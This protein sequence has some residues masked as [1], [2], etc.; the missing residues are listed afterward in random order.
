MMYNIS[1]DPSLHQS[2]HYWIN[3]LYVLG[4]GLRRASAAIQDQAALSKPVVLFLSC[5]TGT[6]ISS[7]DVVH[8][9]NEISCTTATPQTGSKMSDMFVLIDM[10]V[11]SRYKLG[12][13]TKI[14]MEKLKI[15][16]QLTERKRLQML[17]TVVRTSLETR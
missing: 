12:N 9:S 3:P 7:A 2:N 14:I 13:Q 16:E 6:E 10:T 11:S 15:Q 5:S 17:C 1:T 8:A 4:T